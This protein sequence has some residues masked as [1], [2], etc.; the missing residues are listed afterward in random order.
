MVERPEEDRVKLRGKDGSRE[1]PTDKADSDIAQHWR[2]LSSPVHLFR[3][4]AIDLLRPRAHE[5]DAAPGNDERLETVR[6]Q[7]R[8]QL[9]HGL[10]LGAWLFSVPSLAYFSTQLD[11]TSISLYGVASQLST[12]KQW[13]ET[14]DR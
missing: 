14:P 3:G 10:S 7:A 11:S 13:Q 2:R 9:E 5:L 4:D 12:I 6:L 8:D 1:R